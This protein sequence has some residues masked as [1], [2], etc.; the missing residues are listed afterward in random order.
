MMG[1]LDVR[2]AT[3]TLLRWQDLAYLTFTL[4]RATSFTRGYRPF[5]LRR[6]VSYTP[7]TKAV[8]SN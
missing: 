1:L 4:M 2:R 7:M 8:F 5:L 6:R 3:S